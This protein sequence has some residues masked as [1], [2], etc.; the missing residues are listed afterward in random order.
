MRVRGR[1]RVLAVGAARRYHVEVV[2]LHL[3]LEQ[4]LTHD[5]PRVEDVGAA[6]L[7]RLLLRQHLGEGDGVRG[8]G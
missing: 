4:G 2:V 1:V 5:I 6:T 8:E 7:R 3:H